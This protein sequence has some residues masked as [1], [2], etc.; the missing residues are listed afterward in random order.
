MKIE[1]VKDGKVDIPRCTALHIREVECVGDGALGASFQG[2]MYE[3]E[4]RGSGR[5][6]AHCTGMNALL[7]CAGPAER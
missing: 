3:S 5:M 1:D 6:Y 2:G 4:G 7:D